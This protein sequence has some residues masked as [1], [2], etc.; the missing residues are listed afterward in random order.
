MA[1]LSGQWL[2]SICKLVELVT[3]W[4]AGCKDVYGFVLGPSPE[5]VCAQDPLQQ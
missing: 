1:F 4:H 3:Q 2:S 5:D